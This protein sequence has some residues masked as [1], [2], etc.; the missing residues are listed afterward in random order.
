ML[1][2]RLDISQE[3]DHVEYT[4][5]I[6]RLVYP[7]ALHNLNKLAF[8]IAALPKAL[9]DV[10]PFVSQHLFLNFRVA[11]ELVKWPLVGREKYQRR[12]QRS[13]ISMFAPTSA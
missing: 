7:H 4:W 3:L 1:V 6:T 9:V 5:S 12:R 8:H 13:F 11:G 10:R 2:H